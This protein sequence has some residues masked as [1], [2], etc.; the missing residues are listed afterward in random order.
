MLFT[1]TPGSPLIQVI[2][3]HIISV[4]AIKIGLMCALLTLIAGHTGA[5]GQRGTAVS[6]FGDGNPANGVEDD[7][8]Q[9]FDRHRERGN[10][11]TQGLGV[12]TIKC[13]GRI[14]GTAMVLNTRQFAP[15]LDGAVL[16]SAA[17]VLYDLKKKRPFKR[18]DFH[19]LA[20]GEISRYRARIDLGQ[21]RTGGFDPSK[22]TDSKSFG[23][24]DWAFLYVP[25]PWRGFRMAE[26]IQAQALSFPELE[27]FRQS[28]GEL[29]LIAYDAVSRAISISGNCTVIESQH[30]DL[31]GGAWKGQLLDN[32]DSGGGASGGGIVA[33]LKGKQVLVGI[34][35]GSHWSEEVFPV[36]KYP[37]GPPAGSLWDRKANTNFGRAIDTHLLREL[38]LF[39]RKLESAHKQL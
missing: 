23:V 35:S 11:T 1:R 37:A 6:I 2:T 10:G 28:G 33:V 36:K 25:R 3:H 14:R 22:A 5:Q 26:A 29:R 17:H 32:C 9:I 15:A 24:G 31:G 12:G 30:D 20:L 19:Y 39:S 16:I 38:E 13:D 18:C 7:R 34:R 8:R 4:R 21:V 27:A